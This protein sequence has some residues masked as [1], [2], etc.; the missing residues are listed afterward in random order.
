MHRKIQQTRKL[1]QVASFDKISKTQQT[2]RTLP[3]LQM[4]TTDQHHHGNTV[5]KYSQGN[6]ATAKDSCSLP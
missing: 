1:P 2:P 5:T 3:Q 4:E 6:N